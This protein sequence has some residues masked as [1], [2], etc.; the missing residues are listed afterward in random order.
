MA[1]GVS[2]TITGDATSLEEFAARGLAATE[3]MGALLEPRDWYFTFGA[4]HR[5]YGWLYSDVG[6]WPPASELGGGF[7][8]DDRYVVIHGTHASARARMVEFFGQVWC[9]QYPTPEAAGVDKYNLTELVLTE[10]TENK[11]GTP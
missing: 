6:K 10:L 7:R 3:A 9:A 2:M 11:E 4:G 8:L 5:A 1:T